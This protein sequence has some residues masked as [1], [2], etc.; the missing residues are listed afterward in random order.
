MAHMQHMA[1]QLMLVILMQSWC[2]VV[3]DSNASRLLSTPRFRGLAKADDT[4]NG[5][6]RRLGSVLSWV[7]VNGGSLLVGSEP[8]TMFDTDFTLDNYQR[9]MID[10]L[11]AGQTNDNGQAMQEWYLKGT[12]ETNIT[13]GLIREGPGPN[14]KT[15]LGFADVQQLLSEFPSK[16]TEGT[17][18]R[19][20]EL[21][22]QVLGDG[23]WPEA[24]GGLKTIGLGQTRENHA[25]VRPYLANALDKGS[26]T[27]EWL[28]EKANAF[29]S[30]RDQFDSSDVNWWVT[31]V[32]HKIHVDIDMDQAEAKE[33]SSYMAN[34]VRLIPFPESVL[35]SNVLEYAL[36][37]TD[38]L[39]KKATYLESLKSA[40]KTKYAG[41]EFVKSNNDDQITLLASVMLD[42]LQFAGGISV[43]TV[44]NSVLA[45]THTATENRHDS[46]NGVSLGSD[47]YE[48]ILWETLRKYAPVAGVPSWE[49]QEDGSF[50]HVVSNVA[51]ALMDSSVFENP[52]EFEDRGSAVYKSTLQD[53]GMP[54]AGPAVQKFSDGTADIA[55]PHSHSCPAQDLSFRMMK[56]FIKAFIANG[57][58]SGWAA[59]EASS[60]TV[61]SYGPSSFTLLKRGL[62]YKT[63][64]VMNPSCKPGYSWVKTKWGWYGCRNWTCKV[65]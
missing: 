20:N 11:V 29:F 60:I 1:L 37:V 42:S 45:L 33:F 25:F 4:S 36:S 43:P 55:A 19:G 13:P 34:V 31:Q 48:W 65:Q 50:K 6:S 62:K 46:L 18:E 40:I 22:M 3:G 15:H 51:Q 8:I 23:A 16:I 12:G 57:D 27:D 64:C 54:W 41:K 30:N 35:D 10:F 5:K 49:K 28:Q 52:M 38:T 63:G 7:A 56:A 2:G 47:N 24:P 53:A 21:G 61:T 26:W 44:I 59:T 39:A 9:E 17:L 14:T 58:T 32:L